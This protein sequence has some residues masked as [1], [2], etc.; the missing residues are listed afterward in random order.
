MGENIGACAR[1][2]KNF[3]L[4]ELRIVSPRDGWPN[5]KADSMSVGA[6]DIIQNAKI[7]DNI[8]SAIADIE[9]LYATTAIPRDMNKPHI[10]TNDLA[11]NYPAEQKVGIM[12]GRENCGLNNEEITHANMILSIP[13]SEFSSMNIAHAVAVIAYEV[14]CRTHHRHHPRM[15]GDTVPNNES[16]SQKLRSNYRGSHEI[17]GHTRYD[18]KKSAGSR[19]KSEMTERQSPCS[20]GELEY[21]FEHLFSELDS[22][23]FFKVL[24]KRPQ[25]VQNIRNI[26]TRIDSLSK[27]E[28]QTLR[29]ILASLGK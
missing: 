5:P 10:M 12:F 26:F 3:G 24:E 13:T 9:Y 1:A 18:D 17:Q 28:L 29:G 22:H 6:I 27:N 2:M 23:N 4:S 15:L 20:R 19:I 25:M 7:Y 21:F 16:S 11:E 8:E 14:G